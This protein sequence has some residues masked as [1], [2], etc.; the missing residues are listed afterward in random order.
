MSYIF[1]VFS[2]LVFIIC[3]CNSFA[4]S[5]VEDIGSIFQVVLPAYAFGMAMNEEGWEGARQFAC[6]FGAMQLSVNG[7]K[8]IINEKRPNGNGNNSFP[9]GHAAAAFSGAA[10]IHKR[11]G[12]EKA[13][14]PYLMAGFTGYSRVYAD[15][16]YWHDVVAGAAISSLF[17]WIFVSKESRLQIS[18][19]PQSLNL[20]FR[21]KF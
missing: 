10:F 3:P 12:L 17:T 9:S 5:T 8:S 4:N 6:L 20:M 21:A 11:Y 1:A 14:I 19:S 16:H 13:L 7:L 15:K 2:V 18:G